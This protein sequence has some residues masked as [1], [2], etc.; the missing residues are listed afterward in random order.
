MQ[1]MNLSGISCRHLL[2]REQGLNTLLRDLNY[3]LIWKS[4]ETPAGQFVILEEVHLFFPGKKELVKTL[5]PGKRRL[6]KNPK[7][8][9]V[10]VKNEILLRLSR[11]IDL[12]KFSNFLF[13]NGL[14]LRVTT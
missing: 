2:T 14:A 5:P 9:S 3:V 8:G 13:E 4:I 12:N 1:R 6:V 10:F 11:E 7:D